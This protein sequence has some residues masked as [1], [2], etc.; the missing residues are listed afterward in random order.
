[1][2]GRPDAD[3]DDQVGLA[4]AETV[5]GVVRQLAATLE[6]HA[7]VS[8]LG[9]LEHRREVLRRPIGLGIHRGGRGFRIGRGPRRGEPVTC[10]AG[11]AAS[12]AKTAIVTGGARGGATGR[13][14]ASCPASA[15]VNETANSGTSL[16]RRAKCLAAELE[17]LGVATRTDRGGASL[18]PQQ[19]E[20]PDDATAL[21]LA[22][23]D[24]GLGYHLEPARPD[25]VGAAPRVPGPEQPLAG[26]QL[27]QNGLGRKLLPQLGRHAGED[28]D[29]AEEIHERGGQGCPVL[30]R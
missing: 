1:M 5:P 24:A 17:E 14:A 21:H 23:D 9:A 6:Q 27:D 29:V 28:I 20:L 2:S 16:S 15:R 19:G 30:R 8:S 25:D 26:G 11:A 13:V 22:D 3:A 7:I 4:Q 18:L 10:L 12:R